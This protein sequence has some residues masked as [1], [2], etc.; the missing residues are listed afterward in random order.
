MHE[1]Q[2]GRKKTQKQKEQSLELDDLWIGEVGHH[3][4]V[5]G[6][7]PVDDISS[8]LP[9]SANVCSTKPRF[10]DKCVPGAV[11]LKTAMGTT[12]Y[13]DY[14]EVVTRSVLTRRVR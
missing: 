13:A 8:L 4:M 3:N 14:T 2:H 12:D 11:I 5:S 9:M 10:A 7:S 6:K 1:Q